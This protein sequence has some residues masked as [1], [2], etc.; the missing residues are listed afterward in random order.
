M[1]PSAPDGYSLISNIGSGAFSTVWLAKHNETGEQ[2]AI[3][4]TPKSNLTCP[5][6][7]AQY[8]TE[9]EVLMSCNHPNIEKFHRMCDDMFNHF[10]VTEYISGGSL[11]QLMKRN[12]TIDEPVARKY[13]VQMCL[14]VQ[15]LHE[16]QHV[17]H[18]DLKLGNV[19]IDAEDNIKIIDF[20][21][22]HKLKSGTERMTTQC[23]S[24]SIFLFW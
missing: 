23:G 1:Q 2:V 10:L 19:M 12:Y 7:L 4:I 13:F 11:D 21:L 16:T 9:R 22:S 20:G 6:E 18:R 3:K 14:A 24:P 5:R 17:V 15:Y 8:Y